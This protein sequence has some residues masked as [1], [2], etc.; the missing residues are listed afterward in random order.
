MNSLEA[1]E[2]RV[3]QYLEKESSERGV[4]TPAGTLVQLD[5]SKQDIGSLLG[6]TRADAT[7]VLNRLKSKGMIR[8]EGSS[9]ILR[10]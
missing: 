6:M 2:A 3:L 8:M 10:R 1:Q 4:S 5:L 9:V 7:R